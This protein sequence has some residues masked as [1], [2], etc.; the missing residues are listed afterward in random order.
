MVG[1]AINSDTDCIAYACC[2]FGIVLRNELADRFEIIERGPAPYDLHA[3]LRLLRFRPR[4]L[5]IGAPRLQPPHDILVRD[6]GAAL[7]VFGERRL[8]MRNLPRV[9][10][11]K[12]FNRLAS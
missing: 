12:S 8:N 2:R 4:Q 1:E 11:H 9:D 3:C 10:I 7:L 6:T 5:V